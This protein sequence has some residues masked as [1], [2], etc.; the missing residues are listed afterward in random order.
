MWQ[1]ADVLRGGEHLRSVGALSRE[2]SRINQSLSLGWGSSDPQ[3]KRRKV[4]AR[5]DGSAV[6]G[7]SI[8]TRPKNHWLS[9]RSAQKCFT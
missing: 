5:A 1:N 8:S 6:D 2:S 4:G 3:S 9:K 7:L